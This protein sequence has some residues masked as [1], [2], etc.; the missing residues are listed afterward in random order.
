MINDV[1]QRSLDE[2]YKLANVS[3]DYTF[4]ESFYNDKIDKN[5]FYYFRKKY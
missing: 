2:I 1:S 5:Y 3:F 4:G